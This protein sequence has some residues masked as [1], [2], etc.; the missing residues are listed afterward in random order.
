[1]QAVQ[2]REISLRYDKEIVLN[3][4]DLSVGEGQYVVILGASGCGKTSLLRLIAGLITPTAGTICIAGRDVR[5]VAPSPLRCDAQNAD[6][7]CRTNRSSSAIEH[8]IY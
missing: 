4:V 5:G 8:T 7:F 2:L 6:A 1:M 3:G